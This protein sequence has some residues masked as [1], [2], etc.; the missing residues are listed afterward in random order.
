MFS[1]IIQSVLTAS[2]AV[3]MGGAQTPPAPPQTPATPAAP[4]P[5]AS[6][7]GQESPRLKQRT[8]ADLAREEA[9]KAREEARKAAREAR[10]VRS[11]VVV[12]GGGAYLGL[13]VQDVSSE[14]LAALKLK[15]ERGV[16][17]TNVDRDGPASKAGVRENDVIVSFNGQPV[18]SYEQL[19]RM[20]RET[21]P[22]RK[23][24]LGLM[25]DGQ[26]Q[27]AEVT[28]G[29]RT[30]H[31]A[32]SGK[33]FKFDFPKMT[34]EPFEMDVPGFTVLQYSTRNGVMVEDLTPQLRE[35]FGVRNGGGVLVRSVERNSPAEQAG[36]KAGDVIVRVGNERVSSSN[37]WRRLMR[38]QK[39][40]EV[41]LGVVREKREMSLSMKLPERTTSDASWQFEF[42]DIEIDEE[43][44]NQQ[45][46]E[47]EPLV[48]RSVEVAQVKLGN[49]WKQHQKQI[50][51]EIQKA[52]KELDKEL[53]K[54]EKLEKEK[55]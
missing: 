47:I 10:R 38:Q 11:V 37:E 21:P 25:R 44:I 2:L 55:K 32:H 48:R 9:R 54:Q 15:E 6:V 27:S 50:K 53:E 49:E 41:S 31:F 51:A 8:D 17:V 26:P 45:I 35:F 4:A 52:M 43:M 16:E 13:G 29:K 40:A 12:N 46:R 36:I 30:E 1:R 28:L 42:P 18:E 3:V 24:K 5:Q 22:G 19:R 33:P 23:V 7:E 34:V 20:L 39:G 14:R